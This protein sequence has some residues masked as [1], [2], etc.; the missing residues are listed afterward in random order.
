VCSE[1]QSTDSHTAGRVRGQ[2]YGGVAK[3]FTKFVLTVEKAEVVTCTGLKVKGG[4]LQGS[5]EGEPGK[6]E[7]TFELSGCIVEKNGEDCSVEEPVVSS[8]LKSELVEDAAT[9]KKLG[10]EFFAAAGSPLLKIKFKGTCKVA[11][12]SLTGYV[13]AEVLTDPGEEVIELEGTKHGSAK[14]W[15]FKIQ[16]P[17]PTH[18]WLIH[19]EIGGEVSVPQLEVIPF[20]ATLTGTALVTLES[21]DEWSPLP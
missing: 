12:A 3:A 9:K 16:S 2:Q 5:N 14:S 13:V 8:T 4:I 6:D 10:I 20:R 19:E 7:E 18:V 15:L 17:Q 11:G 1:D 21:G